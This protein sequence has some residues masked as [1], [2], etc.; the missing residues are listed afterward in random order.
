VPFKKGWELRKRM[1]R[2]ETII[3][4]TGH[5]SAVV[6]IPYLKLQSLEF[7]QRRLAAP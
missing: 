4:P 3:L 6:C 1:G 2:P 5:Y 7:L